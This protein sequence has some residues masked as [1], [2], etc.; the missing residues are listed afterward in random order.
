[1][2]P[3]A[4]DGHLKP[5][6]SELKGRDFMGSKY[7]F[8]PKEGPAPGKYNTEKAM[9]YIKPHNRE[10]IIVGETKSEAKGGRTITLDH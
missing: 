10:V 2:G 4:H 5:F 8:K 3:G 9:N 6:G 1:M 7:E